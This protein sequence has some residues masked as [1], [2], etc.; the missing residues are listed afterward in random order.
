M[1][2]QSPHIGGGSVHGGSE[3]SSTTATS[4]LPSQSVGYL[5]PLGSPGQV[6]DRD[7]FSAVSEMPT[8][9]E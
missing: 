6:A 4:E 3:Y 7:R 8:S 9:R 1:G 5:R 2:G